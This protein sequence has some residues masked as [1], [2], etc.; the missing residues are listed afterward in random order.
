MGLGIFRDQ[1]LSYQLSENN[2]L[3]KVHCDKLRFH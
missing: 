1:N 2:Q 3:S